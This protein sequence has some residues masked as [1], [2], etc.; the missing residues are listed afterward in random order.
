MKWGTTLLSCF[1]LRKHSIF[2]P[3][4]II[5]NVDSPLFQICTV[6]IMNAYSVL[7]NYFYIWDDSFLLSVKMTIKSYFQ[8]LNHLC[9]LLNLLFFPVS[10]KFRSLIWDHYLF[11]LSTLHVSTNK[12]ASYQCWYCVFLFSFSSKCCCCFSYFF[13]FPLTL[14][15]CTKGYLGVLWNSQIF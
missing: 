6:F 12:V 14:A 2:L 8:I 15:F 5:L 10:Y 4:S 11:Y 3:L 1:L 7:S 9:F 13:K